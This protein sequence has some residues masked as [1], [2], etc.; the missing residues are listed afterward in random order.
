MSIGGGSNSVGA[1][2]F[3]PGSEVALVAGDC[4]A[5]AVYVKR[6]VAGRDGNSNDVVDAQNTPKARY[7][8]IL[9]DR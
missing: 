4:T 1:A 2:R 8:V 7:E 6:S 3:L 9:C 5:A